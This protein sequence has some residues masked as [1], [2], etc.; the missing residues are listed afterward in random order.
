MP[1]YTN[2]ESNDEETGLLANNRP[3]KKKKT[4]AQKGVQA[5]RIALICLS[6]VFVAVSA[7]YQFKVMS[8]YQS[9]EEEHQ[10]VAQLDTTLKIHQGVIE[11]FN[12]SITN[13]DVV[14][15]LA[16][17]ETSLKNTKEGLE[18]KL[19]DV[20]LTVSKELNSTLKQLQDTV[21]DAENEIHAE[22]DRVKKDVESYVVE[23]QDRFSMENSFM[24]YQLAGTFTLLSCLISMWHMTAHLRKMNQPDVQRKILAILWMSPIYAITS[25]FSLVFHSAEGY[26]A[27][28]K[29]GY[30]AYIIY[31][32]LSFLISVL[33]KGDRDKVVDLLSRRADHLTPPFR[34][35]GCF[36]LCCTGCCGPPQ[37]ESNR[38]LA[39]EILLQCQFFA[40]QFVFFRPL[41]TTAMVVLR[42][43]NYYG[44]GDGPTDYRSP[45]FYITI[46]QNISIFTAFAG[47]L[48]FYH[49]VDKDLAW[50]R[51]FAKFLC[52]KG[53]VFMTF[54]QG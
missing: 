2:L 18:T 46:V 17:L 5:N 37:Y 40:M 6:V 38:A 1:S 20:E 43:L 16:A 52:I 48:K 26:L 9:L 10:H 23:T 25:W 31:Q 29:D 53:V 44:A 8:L 33:G 13:T 34:L 7:Y 4:E 45:Q 36:E 49:A 21:S 50:C 28:I 41:T 12:S 27:I 35:F 11:R 19:T 32:F 42:E 24:V 54:W 14:D 30:E 51:P 15:R 47:L 39:D 3:K 22:V